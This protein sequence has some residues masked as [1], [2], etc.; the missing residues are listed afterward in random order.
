[1]VTAHPNS[2]RLNRES[3]NGLILPPFIRAIA[4]I[5]K[6]YGNPV[7]IPKLSLFLRRI[8]EG[9]SAR[10]CMILCIVE[11]ERLDAYKL[12]PAPRL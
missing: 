1:M 5:L 3:E 7:E 8:K 2:F 6:S 9:E 4:I 11:V 10:S 12:M